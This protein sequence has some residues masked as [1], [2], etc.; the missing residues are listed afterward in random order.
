MPEKNNQKLSFDQFLLSYFDIKGEGLRLAHE[1]FAKSFRITGFA[2]SAKAPRVLTH[3]KVAED[4]RIARLYQKAKDEFMLTHEKV[5]K[6]FR[7]NRLYQKNNSDFV[8]LAQSEPVSARLFAKQKLE[9]ITLSETLSK[10]PDE[11]EKKDIE[12]IRHKHESEWYHAFRDTKDN[13]VKETIKKHQN[14]HEIRWNSDM[15]DLWHYMDESI[16]KVVFRIEN[17]FHL[18]PTASRVIAIYLLAVVISLPLVFLSIDN[19]IDLKYNILSVKEEAQK[20]KNITLDQK[21]KSMLVA[22]NSYSIL[23]GEDDIVTIIEGEKKARVLGVSEEI[24]SNNVF[25]NKIFNTYDWM[26]KVREDLNIKFADF[27]SK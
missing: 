24:K 15:K 6:D 14:N 25:L 9:N 4:F 12:K 5:A 11:V 8:E 2:E 1:R 16:E 3:E 7:L 10:L 21:T 23:N 13:L 27:I 18:F 26:L 19:N 17:I 20:I 22:N